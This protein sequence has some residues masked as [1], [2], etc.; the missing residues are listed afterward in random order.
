[1]DLF[2][3]ENKPV[4]KKNHPCP[5]LEGRRETSRVLLHGRGY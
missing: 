3:F 4:H 5:L 1:M 2:V